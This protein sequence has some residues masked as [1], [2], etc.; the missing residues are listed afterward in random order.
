MGKQGQNIIFSIVLAITTW[1]VL[2]YNTSLEYG[3]PEISITNVFVLIIGVTITSLIYYGVIAFLRWALVGAYMPLIND[4]RSGNSK[5]RMIIIIAVILVL[6]RL[7][8][9][10]V[11]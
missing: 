5:Q 6:L 7:I 2:G 3:S 10:A 11:R 4:F 1:F 8:N 9:T